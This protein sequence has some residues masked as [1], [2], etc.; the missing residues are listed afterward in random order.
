MKKDSIPS[1]KWAFLLL[2]ILFLFVFKILVFEK[3][4]LSFLH[5]LFSPK[6]ENEQ[7]LALIEKGRTAF[8]LEDSLEIAASL[9]SEFLQIPENTLADHDY[10]ALSAFF[11]QRKYSLT[12][13][14]VL[15][16][17][18]FRL[19][20]EDYWFRQMER[21]ASVEKV[22]DNDTWLSGYILDQ[23]KEPARKTYEQIFQKPAAKLTWK[24][25]C[26]IKYVSVTQDAFT[27][28]TELPKSVQKKEAFEKT[29][30]T[31]YLKD[32]TFDR[33]YKFGGPMCSPL[34]GC[35]AMDI[36][37]FRPST[38]IGKPLCYLKAY[39]RYTDY[40][41]DRF[42]N[43][44]QFLITPLLEELDLTAPCIDTKGLSY[45]KNLKKLTLTDWREVSAD[46]SNKDELLF[47]EKDRLPPAQLKELHFNDFTIVGNSSC[48]FSSLK[49]L[50]ILSFRGCNLEN[51]H[52]LASLT[53]VK[54]L[55]IDGCTL[56][57]LDFLSSLSKLQE[58]SLLNNTKTFPPK[59]TGYLNLKTLRLDS[60]DFLEA[61][62]NS[63]SLMKL[64][65]WELKDLQL[66]DTFPKLEQLILSG[67]KTIYDFA[68]LPVLEH[69]KELSV[70]PAKDCFLE[71]LQN[72]P[73]LLK[74]PALTSLH[75]ER[76]RQIENLNDFLKENSLEKL[77]LVYCTFSLENKTLENCK[78]LISL[79]ING[80]SLDEDTSRFLLP[81][82]GSLTN[83]NYLNLSH[84]MIERLDFVKKLTKLTAFIADDNYIR[85]SSPLEE[86]PNLKQISLKDNLTDEF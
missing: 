2:G 66:L 68:A 35:E 42:I 83:L 58:L 86:L 63:P 53:T 78:S 27:Y 17:A 13:I 23:Y 1:W 29:C 43:L 69:L 64:E 31:I 4:S 8:E 76:V 55:T 48:D 72:L 39:Y 12:G 10:L 81:E 57:T 71:L 65:I 28:S 16:T 60:A 22:I 36:R 32:F 19:G 14:A 20:K 56:K 33:E 50:E 47:T 77:G 41:K 26:T 38:I 74:Q 52:N 44:N 79:T 7:V 54:N 40:K 61:F 45:L 75:M 85:D 30:K 59:Q 82:I 24:E 67:R 46:G 5:T 15:N 73:A 62:S 84:T 37:G 49:D 6:A 9:Y 21:T 11:K 18:R 80:V 3:D 51:A 25:M 34:M 70:I